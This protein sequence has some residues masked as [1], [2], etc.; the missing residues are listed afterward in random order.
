MLQTQLNTLLKALKFQINSI[1][2]HG[3]IDRTMVSRFRTG[4][5]KLS[6][7]SLSIH[8]LAKGILGTAKEKEKMTEL[9]SFLQDT[10]GIN[11]SSEIS[12][13]EM[14]LTLVRYLAGDKITK[15]ENQSFNTMEEENEFGERLDACMRLAMITNVRLSRALNV[16]ASLI[17]RYRSG[18]RSP[19]S[20]PQIMRDM[21][22]I[23]FE[24]IITTGKLEE[25]SAITGIE[26]HNFDVSE[27]TNWLFQ[28]PTNRKSIA[29]AAR[30][31][32]YTLD[33]FSSAASGVQQISQEA[34]SQTE[35]EE[36][37]RSVYYGSNGLRQA[38]LR[39]LKQA[40]SNGARELWLYSDCDISWMTEDKEFWRKWSILM[41]T[42]VQ[43][44]IHIHIVHHLNRKTDEMISAIRG[45]LPLYMSGMVDS[46][47][48]IH[49]TN[50]GFSHVLFV[51]PG[52]AVVEACNV[53]GTEGNGRYR[54]HKEQ[55]ELDFYMAAFNEFLL[56]ARPLVRVL[57]KAPEEMQ[58]AFCVLRPDEMIIHSDRDAQKLPLQNFEFKNIEIRIGDGFVSV[59]RLQNDSVIF[60]ITHPYMIEAFTIFAQLLEDRLRRDRCMKEEKI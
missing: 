26:E 38:S 48:C 31:L 2:N 53:I 25:L 51:C 9:C 58:R 44:K 29:E 32:I 13:E 54:Y 42:C 37:T 40:I 36:D 30:D 50:I 5:R 56:N 7:K 41:G 20:N 55:E 21:G 4:K 10:A 12:D 52:I 34:L 60:F 16:D 49:D 8:K 6:E 11:I 18:S 28:M 14:E 22:M 15:Q 23:L 47:Y 45:W 35:T 43:K 27:F 59:K 39:L 19:R 24:R 57:K 33:S 3:G 1:A 46:Y 17:S